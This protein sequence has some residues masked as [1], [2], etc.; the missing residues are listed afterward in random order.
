MIKLR[1]PFFTVNPKAYLW[2][3]KSL[4]LALVAEEL[5]IKHDV[6]ILFTGQLADMRMLKENTKKLILT[7][8]HLD[9]ITPGRGMGYLLPE[10]AFEAGVRATF[11]NH[12]EHPLSIGDL[13]KAVARTKELGIA[14]ILC[15]NT[16]AETRMLAQLQ[17]EVMVCEP[18]ELIGTGKVSSLEYVQSTNAVVKEISPQTQVLQAA[19]ISTADDVYNTL[20]AGADATG[21][22]SG[23]VCADNPAEVLKKMIEALV[24][25]REELKL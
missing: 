19:G 21:G 16:L 14:T 2:G 13:A 3:E 9:G 11:L 24:K 4:A 15:A 17:P 7:A 25:A 6:D 18:T 23:I 12:A 22:T 8:Q 10:A 20:M 5:A 1:K